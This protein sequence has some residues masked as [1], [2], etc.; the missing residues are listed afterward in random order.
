MGGSP[1]S[2]V[3]YIEAVRKHKCT[4]CT[5]AGKQ[6]L[7]NQVRLKPLREDIGSEYCHW[8]RTSHTAAISSNDQSGEMMKL[9]SS[10]RRVVFAFYP[11]LTH[12]HRINIVC[13]CNQINA[14]LIQF[15]CLIRQVFW[16]TAITLSDERHTS[17]VRSLFQSHETSCIKRY[18]R[19][20]EF[21]HLWQLASERDKQLEKFTELEVQKYQIFSF[22]AWMRC[23]NF[24]S[25]SHLTSSADG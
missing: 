11:H 5:A 10:V 17:W 19:G 16:L 24:V 23:R 6:E 14:I 1:N 20:I 15:C 13:Q 4:I 2:G 9:K 7:L 25:L 21:T 8:C 22:L 12:T 3:T 18:D